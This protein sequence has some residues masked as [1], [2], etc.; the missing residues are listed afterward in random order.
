MKVLLVEDEKQLSEALMQILKQNKYMV[1]GVHNGEDGLDY[2]LTGIYDVIIL[3]IMLPKLNGLEIL[4][5]IREENIST[6]VILLTAKGEVSDK[7]KGLDCG[8][9]DYLPKPFS[10]DELLARLRALTRRKG[11]VIN[12]D[13]LYFGDFS[14]NLSTYILEGRK[15]NV[16]L[17][18]KEL[19]ILK[20]FLLRTGIVVNKEDLIIKIWGYESEA[21]NNNIEVYISFLRKKLQYIGTQAKISTIRGVGYKLEE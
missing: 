18:L 14:L 16:R 3:D 19:E 12:D 15:G 9:D 1:D 20:Y 13:T 8:A 2:A 17:A 10:T 21:E 4:K 11:E 6:P 7:I 5:K